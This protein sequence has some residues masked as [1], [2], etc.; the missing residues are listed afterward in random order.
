M[1]PKWDELGD[2]F[3]DKD[4]IVIAKMDATAN[5]VDGV[6][7]QGFP[8]LKLY[9]KGTNEIIDYNNER[10]VKN[11]AKFLESGGDKKYAE[12]HK[13][14]KK[15]EEDDEDYDEDED[16]EDEEDDSAKHTEL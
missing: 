11:M 5:E 2:M 10:D 13:G 3:K 9:K 7:I 1:A 15:E 6:N 14:P 16:Y 8:T 4:D 12:Q